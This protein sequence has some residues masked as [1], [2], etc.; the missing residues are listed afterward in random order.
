MAT[1]M[2]RHW[3]EPLTATNPSPCSNAEGLRM[4][5]ITTNSVSCCV[6]DIGTSHIGWN[7]RQGHWMI[8][9][10]PDSAAVPKR[11]TLSATGS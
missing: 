7:W 6:T 3:T 11:T 10:K 2:F 4:P 1:L 5:E 9:I 8:A